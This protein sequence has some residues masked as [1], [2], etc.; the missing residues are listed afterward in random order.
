MREEKTHASQA[1]FFFSQI[2]VSIFSPPKNLGNFRK[3]SF[4][5]VNSTNFAKKLPICL[6]SQK[7]KKKPW[8]QVSRRN[9]GPIPGW[10]FGCPM[11][12]PPPPPPAGTPSKIWP[13][14]PISVS[15]FCPTAGPALV[16][17]DHL[18]SSWMSGN[19]HV[20]HWTSLTVAG[21]G[22]LPNGLEADEHL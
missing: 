14:P 19:G 1:G 2:N 22:F 17:I 3:F 7:L 4:K 8:S 15:G 6:I 12:P 5:S 13:Y 9:P 16:M 11:E 10:M 21:D 18:N 20:S